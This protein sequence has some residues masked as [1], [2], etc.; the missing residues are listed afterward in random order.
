MPA[1]LGPGTVLLPPEVEPCASSAGR[2]HAV[3]A[4]PPGREV[5]WDWVEWSCLTLPGAG[6][7]ARLSR[8]SGD[9]V[10]ATREGRRNGG[11]GCSA[12]Q[13]GGAG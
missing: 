7:A 5:Q 11:A 4:H 12:A 3:I 1:P 13:R 8:L 2:D 10:K 6:T 9:R